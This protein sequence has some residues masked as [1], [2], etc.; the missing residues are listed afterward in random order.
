M[1]NT[2]LLSKQRLYLIE[3]AKEHVKK[4]YH[5]GWTGMAA[6]LETKSGK[7]YT[8]INVKYHKVWK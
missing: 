1:Q 5:E 8:G 3:I 2:Q 4:C 7:L 6:V